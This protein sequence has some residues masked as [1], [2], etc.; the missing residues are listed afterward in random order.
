MTKHIYKSLHI[1]QISTI[2]RIFIG[3]VFITSAI[4]KFIS[5]EAFDLYVYEHNLFSVDVTETLTRLLIAAE[6]VLGIMLIF[7]IYA[8]Q[9]YYIV[10][11]FLTGFTVYLLLLPV[12][13]NVNTE[14]CYCFGGEFVLT[15]KQSI[16]KN[17]ILLVCLLFVSPRFYTR[18]RWE[19]LMTIILSITLFI[20]IFVVNAPGYLYTVF[21]SEKIKI[22]ISMYDTALQNSGKEKEFT[23]G[24]Q[25][26]CMYSVFCEFCKRSA[27][28]LHLMLKN[29][30]LSEKSVKAIFWSN[31]LESPIHDFFI[32]QNLPI[33]EFTTFRVDTFLAITN[34]LMPVFLFVDNGTVVR[35]ASYITLS[36]R[37]VINFFK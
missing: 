14:N 34:G 29:N 19:S 20:T 2:L 27:T 5:V 18:H 3:L 13:F 32:N 6:A 33:P 12:L 17:V 23:D 16:I 31:A 4:L 24:K 26:I 8:C 36:E 37:E 11:F 7:N 25:I 22:D 30:R 28:K 15:R 9:V 10:L 1:K 21:H 35:K